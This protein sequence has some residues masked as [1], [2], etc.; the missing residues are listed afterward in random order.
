MDLKVN[1]NS[2]IKLKDF[3]KIL[4]ISVEVL[5]YNLENELLSGS[6]IVKGKYL[7]RDNTT[8][9]YIN[10]QIPFTIAF[11]NTDFDI[12]DINCQDLEYVA[13]EGRGVDITFDIMVN[14]DNVIEIPIEII[15]DRESEEIIE[16][17]D[18][19]NENTEDI[20]D[21]DNDIEIL[22]LT[23]L[24]FEELKKEETKRIDELLKSTLEIKDDNLPT[25]EIIIRGLKEGKSNISICYYNDDKELENICK[26]RGVSIDNV[27]KNNQKFDIN[28]YHRI[29]LNEESYG[30]SQ[31]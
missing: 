4:D 29:I 8:E 5:E 31:K 13:I 15:D 10:E 24:D 19:F 12:N 7:K 23:D 18:E 30:R 1:H 21:E 9:E 17:K 28:K 16:A 2:F 22:P 11:T 20:N 14:Y 26:T 27:F 3:F 6:L 25:E